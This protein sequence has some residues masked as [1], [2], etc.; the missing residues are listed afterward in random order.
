VDLLATR[1]WLLILSD[2]HDDLMMK[3]E[4]FAHVIAQVK[5]ASS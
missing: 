4:Y 5:R 3:S 1:L 2:R